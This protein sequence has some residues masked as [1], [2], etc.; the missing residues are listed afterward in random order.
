MAS[1]TR[2]PD[3]ARHS[4]NSD[5]KLAVGL[6]GTKFMGRAHAN[7]WNQCG[8]FFDL[9]REVELRSVAGRDRAATGAFA[10]RWGIANATTDWRCVAEDPAIGLVD[11]LT[12]NHLHA[13][14]AIAALESGRHVACE[15]PLAGTLDDARAMVAAARKAARKGTRTFVWFNY[16]RCPAV[17][18]A[19]QLVKRGKLGRI[20]HV[21]AVYLQDWGKAST[22]LLWRFQADQAGSGAHGDLNAHII[23][24]CRFITGEEVTEVAGAIE[25]TFV[26]ERA[27]V[28]G[29][30]GEISGKGARKAK[31]TGKS[32]VDDCVL[33]L[34]RL[35]GGAVASFEA[36][37]LATGNQNRNAIEINGEKGSIRFD[38]E[39][40]NELEWWDDTL[41]SGLRGWSRI[42]CT[43]GGDHP[44]ASAYWPPAHLI[45]YEHG[46]TSMAA[47]IVR[48]LAGGEPVVPLPDFEDAFRT[49]CVLE[50]AIRSARERRPVKLSEVR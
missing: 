35:S 1:R 38:F 11:I 47:D 42:M 49:Q 50:A 10:A 31:A 17:A 46:F 19:H 3:P 2:R 13:E 28:A 27:I 12:P 23:D 22:P 30:G 7:A 16:R 8:H 15:K 41:E 43:N 29:A 39:R 6:V 9:P 24:L 32:T 5:A 48:T 36:T 45:G 44:Y 34:A 33:F 25:E 18:F 37:R 26:K 40:M 20:H 14:M 21:R 4:P